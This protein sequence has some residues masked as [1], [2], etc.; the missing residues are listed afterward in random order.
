VEA[1]A[2]RFPNLSGALR[3]LCNA[4][5]AKRLW[6]ILDEWSSVP[7]E[8][9]PFLADMLRRAFFTI[10]RITVKIGAIEHRTRFL[11]E[12]YPS[13]A[14][15]LEPTADVRG[16]IRL[17]EFLLFDNDK[18]RSVAFF[19]DFI[20]KHVTSYC[21]E[22]GWPVPQDADHL[23]RLTF[24]QKTSFEE[25][26]KASEGVPRDALHIA[27]MCAQKTYG[28]QIDI[29]NVRSAA[30]KYYQDDKSSQ[31]DSHP[32]LHDLL[33]FIVDKSIRQK[34]T[35]AFLLEVGKRDPNIDLLF[36]RRLIHLRQKNVSSRDRPGVRYFHYKIDYGCYVDLVATRQMPT[37]IEF[38]HSDQLE[39]IVAAVEVPGEDDGRS[40]RR[41]IL[42]IDEFYELHPEHSISL[43]A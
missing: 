19:K 34:R 38:D 41:S 7:Q 17:D 31:V 12:A 10:P 28:K 2:V 15:G 35:N 18:L 21:R 23:Y 13:G 6:I 27:S 29:P 32:V 26:V 3:D 16:N 39:D 14:I 42:E 36:D 9:Q 5:P 37:E 43:K 22:Q 33:R 25:F 11:L 4:L 40:Y 20:F 8:V 24:N 1:L 30:H